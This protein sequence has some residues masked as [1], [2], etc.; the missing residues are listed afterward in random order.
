MNVSFNIFFVTIFHLIAGNSEEPEGG[1]A[2]L[3][4]LLLM[5]VPGGGWWSVAPPLT[6]TLVPGLGLGAG[7]NLALAWTITTWLITLFTIKQCSSGLMIERGGD[8]WRLSSEKWEMVTK[9]PFTN[10][11]S[12]RN[13]GSCYITIHH[14]QDQTG[15]KWEISYCIFFAVK[16]FK[17]KSLKSHFCLIFPDLS[18]LNPRLFNERKKLNPTFG[19]REELNTRKLNAS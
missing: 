10:L 13:G 14:C 17:E 15:L 18:A 19:V 6:V 7:L 8:C 2:P 16:L 11:V 3:A 9:S 4:L 12:A 1:P 5:A